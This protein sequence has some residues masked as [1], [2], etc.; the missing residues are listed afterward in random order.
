MLDRMAHIGVACCR[1]SSTNAYAKENRC[2]AGHARPADSENADAR[3][4]ARLGD[5]PAH[6]ADFPQCTAA[7]AVR[8][9]AVAS[10]ITVA[11]AATVVLVAGGST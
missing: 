3:A 10:R 4:D 6:P 7:T 2:A 1:R 8:G 5:H 9:A 11:R